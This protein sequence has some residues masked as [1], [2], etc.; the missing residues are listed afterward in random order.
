MIVQVTAILLEIA[1]LACFV[2]A[3]WMVSDALGLAVLG[4]V[5]LALSY[6]LQRPRGA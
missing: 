2:R 3:A 6:S 5:L 1:G 4:V